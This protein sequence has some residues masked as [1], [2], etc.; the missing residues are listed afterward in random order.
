MD[1][2]QHPGRRKV[3]VVV[4]SQDRPLEDLP[5]YGNWQS[6]THD[7]AVTT[8]L[9]AGKFEDLV[10]ESIWRNDDHLLSR[11][12]AGTWKEK[13]AEAIPSL[14]ARADITSSASRVFIS[15][16]RLET[17]PLALQLFDALTHEGFDVFLDRFT[18]PFGY[19]FQRRLTQEL[20]DKSMVLLLESKGLKASKWTQHEIDFAKRNRLGLLSVRMPDVDEKG[21]LASVAQRLSP[22]ASE[23]DG[24]VT[25]VDDPKNPG[26][27]VD[28]WPVLKAG[29]LKTIVSA[30]KQAHAD[31]LFT[32]RHRLRADLVTELCR[33]GLQTRYEAL[34]PLRIDGKHLLWPTTRPPQ[35]EDFREVHMA[36]AASGAGEKA[37][38]LIIGPQAAQEPDRMARLQW[39][40]D[41]TKCLSF[42]EGNLPDFA[43]QVKAARWK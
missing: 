26:V 14:L 42:D 43:Q 23:F 22:P 40:S 1:P 24:G 34:G 15:Y 20:E 41:V 4:G 32:R 38:A 28:Q 5:W 7:A 37:R 17:L 33:V 11:V 10:S 9:P 25:K 13:I 19:D 2:A 16:R 21:L 39:L 31:A 29:T 36:H 30:V 35:V 27:K 3:L 8:V 12:N 18:I 6:D